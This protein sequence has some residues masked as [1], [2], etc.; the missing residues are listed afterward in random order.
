MSILYNIW[1]GFISEGRAR[2][3]VIRSLVRIPAPVGRACQSV[4][5][6]DAAGLEQDTEPQIAPD[7]T[8]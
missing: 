8:F 4:L 1:G 3:L 5:E 6:Q 2:P 7:V